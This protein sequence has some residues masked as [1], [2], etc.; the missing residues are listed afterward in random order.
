[1]QRFCEVLNERIA[2]R[3]AYVDNY[4]EYGDIDESVADAGQ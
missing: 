2:V 1:M 4:V 3:R